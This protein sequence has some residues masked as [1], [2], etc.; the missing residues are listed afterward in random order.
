MID[1]AK[2]TKY[3]VQRLLL[4]VFSIL[5]NA[6]ISLNLITLNLD[7]IRNLQNMYQ[8]AKRKASHCNVCQSLPLSVLTTKENKH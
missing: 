3:N 8:V 5:K 6:N 1:R 2:A 4:G 7:C